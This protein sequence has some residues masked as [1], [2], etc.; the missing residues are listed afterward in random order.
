MV[1][2]AGGIRFCLMISEDIPHEPDRTIPL[3]LKAL[4]GQEA[5]R[6]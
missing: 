4:E 5:S 6:A 2:D 1:R 3:V